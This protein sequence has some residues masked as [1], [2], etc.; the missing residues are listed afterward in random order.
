MRA[1][2]ADMS[3]FNEDFWSVYSTS[4]YW[5]ITTFTSVGYGDIIG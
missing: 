3:V 1:E 4:F 2:E 5:V